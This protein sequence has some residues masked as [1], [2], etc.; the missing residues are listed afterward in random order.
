MLH[1]RLAVTLSQGHYQM[2][3]SD[4]QPEQ[5]GLDRES[6]NGIDPQGSSVTDL[7]SDIQAEFR[8]RII[9]NDFTQ[10]W[11][12]AF[13]ERDRVYAFKVYDD[14]TTM[15]PQT[16]IGYITFYKQYVDGHV[17]EQGTGSMS[18][19]DRL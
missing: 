12:A 16:F 9:E 18:E 5:N 2:K 3:N 13:F 11:E 17:D 15:T 8:R 7:Q 10:K 14:A 1:E 19:L 6:I 4:G